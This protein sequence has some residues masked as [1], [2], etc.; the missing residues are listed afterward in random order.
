AYFGRKDA[1]QVAVIEQV[2]NDLDVPVEIVV[3]PTVRDADGLALSSR[4][5]FL[6]PVERGVA[7]SLPRAL[8]AGLAAHRSGEDPVAAARAILEAERG[9]TIDY[10]ALA[11]FDGPTLCAAIRVGATRLI[12]NVP[13]SR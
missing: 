6:S 7:L 8:K 4:N 9:L 3:L 11:D 5:V 2:V 12:D 13:L 10:L 1:Q